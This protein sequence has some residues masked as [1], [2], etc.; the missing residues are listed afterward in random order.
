MGTVWVATVRCDYNV[1]DSLSW[2]LKLSE[3]YHRLGDRMPQTLFRL[4][5]GFGSTVVVFVEIILGY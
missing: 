2:P 3:C 1:C 4:N 5:P